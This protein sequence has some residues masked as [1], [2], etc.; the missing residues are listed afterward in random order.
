MYA[1]KGMITEQIGELKLLFANNVGYLVHC[2]E[3]DFNIEHVFYV[4][5]IENKFADEVDYFCFTSKEKFE[6]FNI[7]IKKPGVGPK[8]AFKVLN[9]VDFDTYLQAKEN[10]NYLLLGKTK[11]KENILRNIVKKEFVK[12]G[13]IK[14]LRKSLSDFGYQKDEIEEI[15][16]QI[17]DEKVSV[18]QLLVKGVRLLNEK[19]T[20]K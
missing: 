9:L 2:E 6:E 16:E 19:R 10:G 20:S 4:N 18:E 13:D 14:F 8:S 5:K 15:L 12:N 3:C 17:Y 7:L 11:V 1:L